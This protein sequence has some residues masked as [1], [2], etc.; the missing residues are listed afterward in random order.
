MQIVVTVCLFTIIKASIKATLHDA[1][2]QFIWANCSKHCII[3]CYLVSSQL[4][5][6]GSIM[7]QVTDKETKT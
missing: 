1:T 5:E 4:Y 2:E 7:N 3:K 6:V